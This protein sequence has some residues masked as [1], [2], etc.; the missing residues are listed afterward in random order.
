MGHRSKGLPVLGSKS[1][2]ADLS[3]VR[4]LL[5]WQVRFITSCRQTYFFIT[6]LIYSPPPTALS[7]TRHISTLQV[8]CSYWRTD[9][10]KWFQNGLAQHN[11]MGDGASVFVHDVTAVSECNQQVLQNTLLVLMHK[12]RLQSDA[13]WVDM[14]YCC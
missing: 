2:A 11:T 7:R 12:L 9:F 10:S 13:V 1:R 5:A 8:Q 4:R 6:W 14:L 3:Q